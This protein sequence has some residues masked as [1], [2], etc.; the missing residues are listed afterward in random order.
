MLKD[1]E[2]NMLETNQMAPDFTLPD[3]NGND[4][5]LSSFRG[6]KVILYFYPKDN[7][8]GCTKEACSLNEAKEDLSGLNAVIIGVSR[9]SAQSHQKFIASYGLSFTL[10]T[11]KDHEVMEM[12]G[13]YGKKMMYGKETT[14]VIRTT[15]IIDEAGK[16]LKIFKKVNTATHGEDIKAFLEE[17]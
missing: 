17:A 16:I 7:T 11:D 2:L 14:G 15:Y 13:A 1:K 12:Y 3:Q 8:P 5:T 9:D 4:V 6:K 10:L